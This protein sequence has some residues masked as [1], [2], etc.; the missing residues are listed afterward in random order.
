MALDYHTFVH[1][2]NLM[3]ASYDTETQRLEI[4]FRDGSRYRYT[5]VPAE[6]W[7]GL[8]RAPSAGS[9]FHRVIKSQFAGIEV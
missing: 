5:T 7:A 8:T 1:S 3:A 6:T 9:Y 2:T 4:E